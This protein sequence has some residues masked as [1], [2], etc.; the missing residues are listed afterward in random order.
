MLLFSSARERRL[1]L[2][3]LAVVVAIYSTLGLAQSLVG[4]LREHGLFDAA[5]D[6]TL[7]LFVLG[8]ILVMATVITQ[9]LKARPGGAEIVVALGVTV[10][11]LLVFTRM[12]I[13][14]E[15][16]HLIEYGVVGVFI[17]AALAERVSQGRRVPLPPLLAILA[18]SVL[19]LLDE[20]IQAFIPSRAF[21]P[22]DI[23][24]NVLAG[25]MAVAASVALGWARRR[26]RS[27]RAQQWE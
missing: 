7:V 24:F 27:R 1:W 10:A 15:R 4:T 23:L 3:T 16:S 17:Y 11:Y 26:T 20:C 22:Q 5:L 2:W 8:M 12:A 19:G 25:T 13:P 18:T 14:T 6:V 9:G 21:D